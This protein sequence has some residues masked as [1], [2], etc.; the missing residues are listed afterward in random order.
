MLNRTS[1]GVAET[2]AIEM[3][4]IRAAEAIPPTRESRLVRANA[5]AFGDPG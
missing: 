2:P 1:S 3:A 4:A 5:R